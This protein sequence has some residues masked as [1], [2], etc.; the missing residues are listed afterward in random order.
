MTESGFVTKINR[1][2]RAAGTYAWKIADR[3]TAGVPDCFYC[4][5]LGT[6]F[7]EYKFHKGKRPPK[8]PKLSALQEMW[9]RN[10]QQEGHQVIVAVGS[11]ACAW[12]YY[13][14]EDL[15]CPTYQVTHNELA[16]TINELC[17][18]SISITSLPSPKTNYAVRRSL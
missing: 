1:A 2:V 17:G 4:G 13:D 12:I 3:L 8:K 9:L 6:L 16:K 7:V 11:P 5:N 18:T 14:M 15:S 10:R